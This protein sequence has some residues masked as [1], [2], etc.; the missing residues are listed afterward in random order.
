MIKRVITILFM[1]LLGIAIIRY[2]SGKFDSMP[3]S[4]MDLQSLLQ[5]FANVQENVFEHLNTVGDLLYK[6]SDFLQSLSSNLSFGS[7]GWFGAF[8]EAVF[9]ILL[10]FFSV[11]LNL[12]SA[13][14]SFIV[15]ACSFFVS[16]IDFFS[17][18]ILV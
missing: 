4:I 9:Q 13:I 15:G 11:I 18:I 6:L 5:R 7:L 2:A 12:I 3:D 14:N 8:L 16:V 10:G 17:Q 1:C